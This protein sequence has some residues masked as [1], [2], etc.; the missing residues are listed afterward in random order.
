MKSL[1]SL[2]LSTSLSLF[3]ASAFVFGADL[4]EFKTVYVLPMS[5]GLDQFLATKLTNGAAL[6]VVT[7][8]MKADVIFTDRI[9]SGF[10]Q[11]LD[12]LFGQKPKV[13]DKDKITG[14]QRSFSSPISHGKGLIFLVD[15]R[16]RN[17]V[18]SMYTKPKSSA[19]DDL[20]HVAGE[21]ASKLE[22]DKLGK[23]EKSK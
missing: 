4:T 13:D 3:A 12:E 16:S 19:P 21:V 11:Q 14:S 15:R 1:L 2:S 22:K 6:Q 23:P 5:S 17:V 9:G 18:W 10:E 7:D 20:N 8:P